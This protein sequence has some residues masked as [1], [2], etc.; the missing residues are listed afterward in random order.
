V[1]GGLLALC[2]FASCKPAPVV[3]SKQIVIS[4]PYDPESLDPH[5]RN[6]ISN[7]ATASQFYEPLV[8]T[9]ANMKIQPALAMSWE[10]PDMLTWIFHLQ[11]NVKFHS[12]KPLEADDIV[13]SFRRLLDHPELEMRAY[14]PNIAEIKRLTSESVQVRTTQPVGVFLNKLNFVLIVPRGSSSESLTAVEDGTGPYRL[15]D[16]KKGEKIIIRRD[17]KYWGPRPDLDSAT[18][19]LSRSPQQAIQDLQSGK[20]QFIQSNTKMIE[21]VV[22]ASNRFK[23]LVHDSL[24]L[25]YLSYDLVNDPTPYCNEKK[26]PFKEKLVRQAIEAAIDR[27]ALINQLSTYS[28]AATQ[29]VPPFVFGYNPALRPGAYDLAQAR[30]LL[31]EAGYPNGF[32]V[33]LHAG[34]TLMEAA[35]IVQAQLAQIGI[36]I[37]IRALSSV[38]FYTA[39]SKRD[40]SFLLTATACPT[41]DA[42]NILEGAMH[43]VNPAA[44][45]GDLN[46]AGYSNPH[47]DQDIEMS[48]GIVQQE[49]RRAVLQKIMKDVMQDLPW[50]PLYIDQEAYGIQNSLHWTPRSDSY[51]FA[52]DIHLQ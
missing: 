20:S 34:R 11:K 3:T 5:Q 4:V 37:N 45:F 12:G 21:R 2:V 1:L 33:T 51:I 22:R 30:S 7:Y 14:L 28:I 41:G 24:F 32:E 36:R 18:F 40:F 26:N 46:Y 9:D 6:T 31:A 29:P 10:N 16:W 50:I 13:Y 15:A 52:R 23:L 35:K 19:L 47:V 38:D 49:K 48:S 25:K 44:Q 8:R 42:S 43:T 39:M 27:P 17:E